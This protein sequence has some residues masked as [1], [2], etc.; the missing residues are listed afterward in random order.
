MCALAGLTLLLHLCG[1]LCTAQD[2]GGPERH[3]THPLPAVPHTRHRSHPNPYPWALQRFKYAMFI[4][5]SYS[6][7]S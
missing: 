3:D 1:D 6:L 5:V 4:P 2:S 7:L